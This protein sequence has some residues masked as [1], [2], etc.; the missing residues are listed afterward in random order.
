MK[1]LVRWLVKVWRWKRWDAVARTIGISLMFAY[2]GVFGL[3]VFDFRW[4]GFIVGV[5]SIP[6][7]LIAFVLILSGLGFCIQ[8]AVAKIINWANSEEVHP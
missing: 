8:L 3:A 2:F 5:V 6:V 7:A 4:Y 1:K